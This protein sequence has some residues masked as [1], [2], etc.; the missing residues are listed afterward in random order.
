MYTTSQMKPAHFPPHRASRARHLLAPTILAPVAAALLTV[1]GCTRSAQPALSPARSPF[2]GVQQNSGTTALLQAVS[3]VSSQVVWVSGHQG[4]Y[5]RTIDGGATWYA[6][7]VPGADSLQF[8]DVYAVDAHTAF[9]M[10]AGAGDLSRVYKTTD[11]GATWSLQFTNH[12]PSAFFDCMDFW[13]ADHGIAMSDEVNGQVPVIMTDDGGQTWKP[14]SAGVLPA[15]LDGEG[16]FAASGTCLVTRPSGH[17]WIG[18]GNTSAA[19]VFRTTDGGRT[20]EVAATPLPSGEGTG[21][22]SMAF[23]DNLHGVIMGGPISDPASR[24][25]N[26]ALTADGGRT[27]KLAGRPTFTGAIYGGTYVPGAATPT[28]VAVGPNGASTSPDDG[29]SWV[30]IDTAAYW[31]VG[32]ASPTAGWAVGPRGRIT[33]LTP[34]R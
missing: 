25:N 19:R 24:S 13:D 26:V 5:A 23:R 12:E 17:A 31:A 3:V 6:A 21:I 10:S 33:K 28:I 9:L 29:H 20:W 14:A 30:P 27:W 22:L 11:A 2:I 34:P 15:A 7:V 4:T 32:F 8:R 1:A 16:G 18:T